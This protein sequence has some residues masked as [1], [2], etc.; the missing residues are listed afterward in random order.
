MQVVPEKGFVLDEKKIFSRPKIRCP[1]FLL[2]MLLF[3]FI[4]KLIYRHL[5]Q[6]SFDPPEFKG[7]I[8]LSGQMN[9]LKGA[10][11][12]FYGSTVRKSMKELYE[13]N[14]ECLKDMSLLFAALFDSQILPGCLQL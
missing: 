12:H 11:T 2:L 1:D 4:V 9:W 13:A 5:I 6:F 8:F 10:K 3:V 14:L 7:L